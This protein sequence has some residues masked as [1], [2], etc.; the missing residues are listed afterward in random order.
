MNN[1]INK[2]NIYIGYR[3]TESYYKT[4]KKSENYNF[5]DY[6]TSNKDYCN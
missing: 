5:K 4:W 3:G 1:F 2:T 6:A